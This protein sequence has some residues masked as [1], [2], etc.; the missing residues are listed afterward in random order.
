MNLFLVNTSLEPIT[1]IT[2]HLLSDDA[3]SDIDNPISTE[4]TPKRSTVITLSQGLHHHYILIQ[5]HHS[6]ILS[7][8]IFD[9]WLRCTCCAK[10]T[11][12]KLMQLP[13][14]WFSQLGLVSSHAIVN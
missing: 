3:M 6:N 4:V 12:E 8:T 11:I 9:E 7:A 2:N 1:Q 5:P 14:C 13:K 10:S